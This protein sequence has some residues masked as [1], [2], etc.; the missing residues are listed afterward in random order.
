MNKEK[1]NVRNTIDFID[2]NSTRIQPRIFKPK[3]E[4]KILYQIIRINFQ[5]K[6]EP[7][8]WE[9]FSTERGQSADRVNLKILKDEHIIIQIC[10]GN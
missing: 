9:I 3:K 6:I 2:R 8:E 10:C 5:P 4:R 7:Q 1:E